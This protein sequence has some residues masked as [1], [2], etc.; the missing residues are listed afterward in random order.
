MERALR[1]LIENAI[2]YTPN[3]GVLIGLRRR[4]SQVR[5]DV[6]DTGIGVPLEKQQE[7]FDEF[8][9]LN[10]PGRDLGQG[11]RPRPRHRRPA[12]RSAGRAQI[13]VSSRVG[14]GSR[15]SLSLPAAEAGAPLEAQPVQPTIRAAAS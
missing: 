1:N 8:I 7:I 13:E 14:R 9:Q 4:G 12:C 3:G 2:R 10:N 6:V 5:I 15:F 11:P